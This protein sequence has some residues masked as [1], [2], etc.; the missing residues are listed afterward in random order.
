VAEAVA[1]SGSGGGGLPRATATAAGHS[2]AVVLARERWW[3]S[4]APVRRSEPAAAAPPA[5]LTL[6]PTQGT[7]EYSLHSRTLTPN[8]GNSLFYSL[9]GLAQAA[10]V[11]LLSTPVLT[12][13]RSSPLPAPQAHTLRL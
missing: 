10:S 9:G 8:Q 12:R 7:I 11:A 1:R 6:S 5:R 3:C 2:V 4:R 13:D